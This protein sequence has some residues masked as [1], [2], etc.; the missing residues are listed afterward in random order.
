MS[1][2]EQ[3]CLEGWAYL[4]SGGPGDS[5]LIASVRGSRWTVFT[6]FPSPFCAADALAAGAPGAIVE[7]VGWLCTGSAQLTRVMEPGDSGPDVRRLQQE[8]RDRGQSVAVDGTFGPGT[9]DALVAEQSLVGTI[10][11]DGLAGPDTQAALGIGLGT[12]TTATTQQEF[13]DIVL[14]W[15]RDGV[16]TGLPSDAARAMVNLGASGLNGTAAWQLNSIAGEGTDRA[17][18]SYV[19]VGDGGVYT[20]FDVCLSG[21]APVYWCGIEY[22][23]GH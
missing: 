2:I 15:L 20:V 21:Q 3:L 14:T 9:A 13:A 12:R 17:T 10:E 8:L 4:D 1:I 11:A 6:Y 5:Q 22:L 16:D 7:R 23:A 19:L 18:A